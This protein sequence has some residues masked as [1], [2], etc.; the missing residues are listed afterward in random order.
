MAK[1]STET[2]PPAPRLA[3]M[4]RQWGMEELRHRLA[5]NRKDGSVM[6]YIPS[7]EFEMGDE[8]DKDCPKHTVSLSDYWIGVYAV[9]NAQYLQFV[10]ATGHRVPDHA[11]WGTPVW[12]GRSFPAEKADHPVVCVSWEDALAYANW[13]GGELPT[14]A[15]WEKAARGPAGLIYPWG[16][17]W[18]PSRCRHAGNKGN[19]ATCPVFGYPGGLSGYGTYNQSGNVWEWCADWYAKDYYRQSP[20]RDPRGPAGGSYRSYRGGCWWNDD[21]EWFRGAYR[22]WYGPGLRFV[23]QG[24][25]LVRPASPSLPS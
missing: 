8:R 22:S 21:P 2:L 12:K 9:T 6:V 16:N 23:H 1:R 13:A 15:Q 20:A 24:F 17:E 18:D 3:D 4:L 5:V 25:R 14:E 10:E 7:G 11:D 19:D